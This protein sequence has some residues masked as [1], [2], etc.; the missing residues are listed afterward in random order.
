MILNLT[1]QELMQMK[2]AVLDADGEEALRLLKEF[3]KR[4]QQQKQA[5]MKSHLDG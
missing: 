4:L 2:S 3:I 1:E 5:G